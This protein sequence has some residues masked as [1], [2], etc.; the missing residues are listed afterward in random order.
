MRA[1]PTISSL[2]GAYANGL[3]PR[4]VVAETY[5]QLAAVGDPGIFITLV[6]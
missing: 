6:P 3:E 5:R 2:H 1:F 4:A